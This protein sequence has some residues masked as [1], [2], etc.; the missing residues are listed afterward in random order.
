MIKLRVKSFITH[1]ESE[2]SADCEDALAENDSIGRY[3]IA[4]GTSQSF[5][6]K[7]WAELLVN[8]FCET[9]ALSLDRK[10]WKEWITP[11]QQEWYQQVEKRVNKLKR[12]YLSDRFDAG[13]AAASTF[14][15]L[16]IDKEKK[17]WKAW[18]IGDSCLFHIRKSQLLK[19]YL[20]ENSEAFTELTEVCVSFSE[21]YHIAPEVV[22]DKVNSGDMLI[23][24]T[25]ALAK[26][27]T[28]YKE[29][30][31]LEEALMQLNEI[32][33]DDQFY[34]FVDCTR[35]SEDIPLDDDDVTLM[36]ISVMETE[37]L[38]PT[39]QKILHTLFWFFIFGVVWGLFLYLLYML[40]R[41]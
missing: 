32:E 20:I 22:G 15:G 24:A 30:G 21:D 33:T 41:R 10:N 9:T 8:H 26:W 11:I 14:V 4:D 6:P 27:V 25:D 40:I 28:E 37:A 5:F 35:A 36:I 16:E 23:L 12:F 7:Q 17:E 13:E 39:Y 38:Q 1:K 34:Q 31:K 29:I 18:I 3:A 19:S 2:T